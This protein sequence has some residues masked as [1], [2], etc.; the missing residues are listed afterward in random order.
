VTLRSH[1]PRL[2]RHEHSCKRYVQRRPPLK[3]VCVR[4]EVW[5]THFDIPKEA[6]TR[7]ERCKYYIPTAGRS[8]RADHKDRQPAI[9]HPQ[10]HPR[11]RTTASGNE[12]PPPGRDPHEKNLARRRDACCREVQPASL[13]D[14][15][16]RDKSPS[17][18][19]RT[20]RQVRDKGSCARRL[21]HRVVHEK[22]RE[23]DMKV[24]LRRERTT[25]WWMPRSSHGLH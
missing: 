25:R 13:M 20:G 10:E 12:S 4:E 3:R 9:D 5:A 2:Q 11:R 15:C 24:T 16:Q 19:Q 1:D 18:G 6:I 14:V 22:R 23:Q 8:R 17:C 21:H 7:S